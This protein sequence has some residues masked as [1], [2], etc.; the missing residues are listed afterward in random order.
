MSYELDSFLGFF[1]QSDLDWI[2]DASDHRELSAG[3]VLITQGAQS[4][5]IYALLEGE[6]SVSVK[7]LDEPIAMVKP[8]QFV[9]EI[10]FLDSRP[11]SATVTAHADSKILRIGRGELQARLGKNPRFA[12][13]FYQALGMRLAQIYR[14]ELTR[15]QPATL[16]KKAELATAATLANMFREAC[17]KFATRQA[18]SVDGQWITYEQAHDRAQKLAVNLTALQDPRAGQPVLAVMLPNCYQLLELF[19]AAALSGSVVFPVNNRLA[20]T[21]LQSL[22]KQSGSG[23]LI[24]SRV[25]ASTLSQLDWD[26]LPVHTIVWTDA[27]TEVPETVKHVQWQALLTAPQTPVAPVEPTIDS[28]LQ[29]FGTSGTTGEPKIILHSHQNVSVHTVVTMQALE[30]YPTDAHCWGHFGPMFHVGDAAFV[31]IGTM[32]GARHV[33]SP[34]SLD[35]QSVVD[36]MASAGV[37]ICKISP[38]MLKLMVLSGAAQKR[39]FPALRWILTG[40][41]APDFT[42]V[43]Q[44]ADLFD[45]DFIQGY[46]MTEATCHVAFKNESQ[47]PLRQG[48][49]VLPGLDLKIVDDDR[50]ELPVGQMGDVAIKGV[51]VFSAQI[52]GGQ[53][54]QAPTSAFSPDGYYLT[55]DLGYL[56]PEGRLHIGGRSKDMINVGGENVFAAEVELIVSRMGG[57][58]QCAAFSMPHVD[59]GEVVEIAIVRTE[60]DV[61][62]QRVIAWCKQLLA[63]YK[64][65]R[66]VYFLEELPLTPTGKVRKTPL[67]ELVRALPNPNQSNEPPALGITD[68]AAIKTL[69][70]ETLDALGVAHT[71]EDQSLFEAGLDSLGAL[72]LI[73]QLQNR[74]GV[75]VAPSLLYEHPTIEAL[76]AYFRDQAIEPRSQT[77]DINEPPVNEPISSVSEPVAV[78]RPLNKVL[79]FLI[80]TLSLLLRPAMLA[81]GLIPTLI[82]A[83]WSAEH[84]SPLQ[85]FLLGPVFLSMM[86]LGTMSCAWA[87]KWL[88]G[89]RQKA[90][91]FVLGSLS[92]YRWLTV[93]NLFRG[94]DS[95]L[96]V[97]RGSATLRLFYQLCGATLGKGVRIDTVDLQDLDLLKV[98][99]GSHIGRDANLQPAVLT[100]G[101]LALGPIA[102]GEGVVIGPQASVFGPAKLPS[103]S[104]VQG[105]DIQTSQAPPTNRT[106][107]PSF[108]IRALGYLLV[109]YAVT[110]A[111]SIGVMFLMSFTELPTL[112]SV[113]SGNTSVAPSLLFFVLLGVV[114]Q[115]V[116]PA[117]YFVIVVILK[118]LFLGKLSPA[119]SPGAAHWIYCRLIDVPLFM[120]FL[121]LTVMSHVMKWAYQALGTKVGARPFIAAPYTAEPELLEIKDGAMVAGN[122][123][124]FA[125]DPVT[126]DTAPVTIGKRAIVANSCLL[127]A[128]SSLGDESLLGDLSRHGAKDISLPKVIAVG[129]PPQAVGSTSL[130]ADQC[131]TLTYAS[132][133]TLLVALQ[134]VIVV[135]GQVLG[136]VALGLAVHWLVGQSGLLLLALLPALLVIPRGVKVLL[137]PI[138]KWGILGRVRAGEHPAYGTMWIRWIALEGLLMDL[139]RTLI[140]LRGT[141]FLPLLYRA[142][143]A[144]VGSNTWLLTS[145]LGSEYDLKTIGS[146]A[147]FNHR[148]L[149]FGHS[150]ERHTLIFRAS[151]TGANAVAGACS[152]VEAGAEV[153]D[154]T[155]IMA[156]K[157]LHARKPRAKPATVGQNLVNLHDFEEAASRTLPGPVFDYFAGGSGD[158]LAL[159]RNLKVYDRVLYVPRVLVDVSRVTTQRQ[160]LGHKLSSPLLAA[161]IAMNRLAHPDGELAV[162]RAIRKLGLGMVL[163]TLSSTPVEDVTSELG[164]SGLSLF[165]LYVLKN[166]AHTESLVHRAHDAGCAALVLTVDAPV[167]GRRERDIRNGFSIASKVDL[168]HLQGLA[169]DTDQRLLAFE[170]SKDPALAWEQL[171]WLVQTSQLPVWLK[172]VMR[173]E[174]AVRAV[175]HGVS[176]LILSNHGGRQL[177]SSPSALEALQAVKQ[178]L[179]KSGHHVP[180][181]IDGG[182]RRG[183]HI[184]K[185]LALGAD[186]VLVG[187]PVIWGLATSG[188]AGVSR[189]LGTLQ[190]ELITA[191]RLAGSP[192]L[193][194]IEPRGLSML[195]D[196]IVGPKSVLPTGFLPSD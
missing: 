107:L 31:W 33:F 110:A 160:L 87:F 25:Y 184:L 103:N 19:Y 29:C 57:V 158:Q 68:Q 36:L 173:A 9:G 138:A 12:A 104:C 50:L 140:A 46:G 189:V 143:G 10:S 187:R 142:M 180:V 16:E 109:A 30:L 121:R 127:M 14:K 144:R 170:R 183:E 93:N 38:S 118:R 80:Q 98:G 130:V 125:H 161:P 156:H 192:S 172:G 41:A 174:D 58:K 69:I 168:P 61:T 62:A 22:L 133:Q 15:P 113:L 92:Y 63:S 136:F 8:G 97:L 3:A 164:D 56:D 35:F 126:G 66:K 45:C 11:T 53:P 85:L 40:G 44:T 17:K 52:L 83:Q 55:G 6:L 74:L 157:P 39:T 150:I 117:A 64:V 88:I 2:I 152:I 122:V 139:E 181:L 114:T 129:R 153:P 135:G 146:D 175:E 120:V 99:A 94:L 81:V 148:S 194:D 26:H 1:E 76:V 119:T 21:E 60:D 100:D 42:L 78:G 86:L 159:S 149:V 116:I 155:T 90:G 167:S 169:S 18:Y 28:F 20:A 193:E 128:G 195:D 131:T 179:D 24:T 123:A 67:L 163:S 70:Q 75:V 132:L 196:A 147:V 27:S 178:A 73:E 84:I 77:I 37:T 176:G 4:E 101:V 105:L 154:H 49:N 145:S 186:A 95:T 72:D 171:K 112:W 188:E 106:A 190:E 134:L 191:M 32:L 115:G 177:D 182:I 162:A 34:N 47:A 141:W 137:L 7:G 151:A 79:A 13:R 111:I 51:T 102:I 96:G 166:R 5:G 48:M 124:I 23:I 54:V 59:L 108:G 165:Q 71:Q 185:A 65:P 91:R 43:R 89:G 82:L